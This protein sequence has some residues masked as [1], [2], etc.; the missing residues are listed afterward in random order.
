MCVEHQKEDVQIQIPF[1][2]D[3]VLNSLQ[4]QQ[5]VTKFEYQTSRRWITINLAE[6]VKVPMIRKS[7]HFQLTFIDINK[8]GRKKKTDEAKVM[9]NNMKMSIKRWQGKEDKTKIQRCLLN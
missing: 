4:F 9:R 1:K 8:D 2:D 3:F 7:I 5:C 6:N